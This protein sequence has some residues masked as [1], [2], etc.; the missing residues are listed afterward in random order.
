MYVLPLKLRDETRVV[1]E[2]QRERERESEKEEIMATSL[3]SSVITTTS[4]SIYQNGFPKTSFVTSDTRKLF[5][6][7]SNSSKVHMVRRFKSPSASIDKI[8]K[9]FREVH[10]KE[11]LMENYK[12]VPKYLY[13]LSPSQMDMFST[14]DS[15][16]NR[17]SSKVTE[18]TFS[19][20]WNYSEHEGRSSLSGMED[21][22]ATRCSM[23]ARMYG[24]GGR[25]YERR[26]GPP[27]DLPSILLDNRIVY[28]GMPIVPAVSELIIAQ[29]IYL[30]WVDPDEPI[31]FYIT[32]SGTLDENGEIVGSETDAFAIASYMA[33]TKAK[34]Y[35]INMGM[36]YGQAALLL[37]LGH[38]AKIHLPRVHRS[39]GAT[40]DMWI[41]AK[42]LDLDSNN[43]IKLLAKGIGKP[44][45][46][47]YEDVEGGK[48][49]TAETAIEYGIADLV[50]DYSY[51][52]GLDDDDDDDLVF[53]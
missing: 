51:M 42:D 49:F 11:G 29:L 17:Q 23:S 36:A 40:T 39:S 8:P 50:A 13:G 28:L 52:G 6:N 27:P 44:I 20:A 34:Y 35:T 38:K 5:S 3:I 30:S 2:L 12:N 41:K 47:I 22:G 46:E 10:L 25:D 26:E 1:I 45:E 15:P 37:S 7:R 33:L 14:E 32:S 19:A 18:E 9:Q 21:A 4:S 24:G 16:I 31:Y 53:L 43:Y 48:H